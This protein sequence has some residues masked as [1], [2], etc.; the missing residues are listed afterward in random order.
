MKQKIISLIAVFCALSCTNNVQKIVKN[1]YGLKVIN[2]KE[3]YQ[4][5]IKKD[6]SK[7]MVL[8]KNYVLNIIFDWKYASSDNFTNQVLYKNPDAFMRIEAAENLQKVAEDLAKIGLGLK[9]FDAYRPYSITQKMWQIVPDERYAANPAKGS[10][11]NRGIAV[12]ITLYDLKNGQELLMPTAFDDFTEKAHTNYSNLEKQVI[13]NRAILINTMQKH[14]FI[15]L[16]TEWWHFYLP[17]VEKYELMNID[18]DE[19]RKIE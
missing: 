17:N 10:G 1:E 9:V 11:H 2:T 4:L 7:K 15:V 12:D 3:Q 16:E 14:G 6:S 13:E 18:F 19:L 8:L 5:T